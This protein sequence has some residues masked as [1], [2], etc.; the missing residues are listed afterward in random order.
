M[1]VLP[2]SSFNSIHSQNYTI[3]YAYSVDTTY[4]TNK[5][6]LKAG[7][8]ISFHFTGDFEIGKT[9][10]LC[11]DDPLYYESLTTA[12]TEELIDEG[13]NPSNNY[14]V[15]TYNKLP[16][17]EPEAEPE[18]EPEPEAEPEPEPEAE[19]EPEPEPEVTRTRTRT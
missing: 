8:S 15:F 9:Y 14:F 5:P 3:D 7:D 11:A 4:L 18:P 6:P 13:A 17:P 16:E 12:D 10:M 19:P 1:N 2:E